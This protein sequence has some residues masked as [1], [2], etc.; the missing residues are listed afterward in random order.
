MLSIGSPEI[1]RLKPAPL[2]RLEECVIH[3][4]GRNEAEHEQ[5]QH[6]HNLLL[7][8]GQ[9]QH[10]LVSSGTGERA[11]PNVREPWRQSGALAEVSYLW[12]R[13]VGERAA[14]H[15]VARH[16]A[17]DHQPQYQQAHKDHYLLLWAR[18]HATVLFIRAHAGHGASYTLYYHI[19]LTIGFGDWYYGCVICLAYGVKKTENK[20]KTK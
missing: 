6:Y 3:V 16:V 12:A 15:E 7:H 19:Y 13:P 18:D 2:N 9:T 17:D 8:N 20:K 11:T 1:Y 5:A 14:S 4:A 10:A